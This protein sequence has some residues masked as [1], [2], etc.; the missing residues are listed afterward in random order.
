VTDLQCGGEWAVTRGRVEV[1]VLIVILNGGDVAAVDDE[2][3][4]EAA[5]S[6]LR[7]TDGGVE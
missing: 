5:R 7:V 3:V 2:G 6:R 4:V 1:Y